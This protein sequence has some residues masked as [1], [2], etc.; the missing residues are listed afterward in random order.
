MKIKRIKLVKADFV[1]TLI[2]LA[3][4]T[5][6]GLHHYLVEVPRQEK[7][8]KNAVYTIGKITKIIS[9]SRGSSWFK[10][11]YSVCGKLYYGQS[12]IDRGDYNLYKINRKIYVAYSKIAHNQ[13]SAGFGDIL[14][15]RGKV[16]PPFC[17]GWKKIPAK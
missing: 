15:L 14:F 8:E 13:S 1:A 16:A 12:L 7:L 9:P 2:I 5:P 17:G 10:Y 3:I 6:L 11:N 4:T